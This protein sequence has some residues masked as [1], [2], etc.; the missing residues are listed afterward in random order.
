MN[1][2]DIRARK[3]TEADGLKRNPDNPNEVGK[4]LFLY[5]DKSV[6]C[7]HW[8]DWNGSIA[9]AK[10]E[11]FNPSAIP[12]GWRVVDKETEK[13]HSRMKYR[14]NMVSNWC[15]VQDTNEYEPGNLYITPVEP[16][17]P[18]EGYELVKPPITI[19]QSR[20]AL[21]WDKDHWRGAAV[22]YD[23]HGDNDMHQD[24]ICLPKKSQYRPFKNAEEFK[25]FAQKEWRYKTDHESTVYP[26]RSYSDR[27][28][29]GWG[30]KNSFDSKI[31][32][33]GT[34]FGMKE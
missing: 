3:P 30:W 25:P 17:E 22:G 29:D 34:P 8:N 7:F 32:C 5:S 16:P 31:F 19:D 18:P 20:R 2:I 15:C 1:W 10:I 33:D 13:K 23:L 4:V 12:D 14:S 28:H 6:G 24:Y 27:G 9:W 26:Q 21:V 11:P